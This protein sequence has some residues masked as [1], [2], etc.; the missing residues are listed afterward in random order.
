MFTY[1]TFINA[2]T[3]K[4]K[5]GT[6]M[7]LFRG[8]WEKGCDPDVVI[9]NCVIDALCFKKRIP[10]A[11]EVFRE[12]KEYGCAPNVATYNSLIKHLRK[13]G[14]MRSG[15]MK[16]E[17]D[18]C[19]MRSEKVD[20]D[21]TGDRRVEDA[22]SYFDN[23]TSKGIVPEPRTEIL[24]NSMRNKLK[25]QEGE[26]QKTDLGINAKSSMLRSKKFKR[27][28]LGNASSKIIP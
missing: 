28:K 17:L 10:E 7:K 26:K 9:C 13:I 12:M 24:V 25:E 27:P 6:A 5:L 2:L 19:G 1:G 14:R 4:G 18:I 23:M 15:I 21:R 3:K 11:L 22:L 8:M 16:R 20:W